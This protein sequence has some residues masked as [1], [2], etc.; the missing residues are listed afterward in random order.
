MFFVSLKDLFIWKSELQRG[1]HIHRIFHV[2]VLIHKWLKRLGLGQAEAGTRNLIK[3]SPV[4]GRG[5]ASYFDYH[6][7]LE[8]AI[9]HLVGYSS[10]LFLWPAAAAVHSAGVS[11]AVVPEEE[12]S[13][14]GNF[15]SLLCVPTQCCLIPSRL[16]RDLPAVCPAQLLKQFSL[17]LQILVPTVYSLMF[18]SPLFSFSFLLYFSLN[19]MK[20]CQI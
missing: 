1:R 16:N 9:L 15:S 20:C 19:D 4:G 11:P 8:E 14:G 10:F 17:S 7:P 12:G 2:L 5:P 13:R 6:V 18:I 3:V